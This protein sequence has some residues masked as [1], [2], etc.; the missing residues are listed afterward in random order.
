M[1]L[2]DKVMDTCELLQKAVALCEV[3]SQVIDSCGQFVIDNIVGCIYHFMAQ[4]CQC[5]NC[6]GIILN[7]GY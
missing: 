6:V 2:S 7:K 4:R 5:I 1:P 3:S